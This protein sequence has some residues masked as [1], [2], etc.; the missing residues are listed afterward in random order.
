VSEED[1]REEAAGLLFV[2]EVPDR[3]GMAAEGRGKFASTREGQREE[4]FRS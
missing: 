2:E 4:A 1:E 3:E